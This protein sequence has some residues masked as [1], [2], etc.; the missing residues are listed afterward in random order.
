MKHCTAK[1]DK[2]NIPHIT[3]CIALLHSSEHLNELEAI[4]AASFRTGGDE[5]CGEG[6]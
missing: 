6:F 3:S 5:F 2:H 4:D 1:H